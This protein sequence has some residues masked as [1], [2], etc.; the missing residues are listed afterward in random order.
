[1]IIIYYIAELRIPQCLNRQQ[2]FTAKFIFA[3]VFGIFEIGGRSCFLTFSFQFNNGLYEPLRST[4]L[5]FFEM[6]VIQSLVMNCFGIFNKIRLRIF[7]NGIIIQERRSSAGEFVSE[8]LQ[9]HG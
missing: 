4:I 7:G 5:A 3:Y 2:V 1:M 8:P 6:K 9:E